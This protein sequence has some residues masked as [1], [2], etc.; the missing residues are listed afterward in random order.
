MRSTI[1][2]HRKYLIDA[3]DR[4]KRRAILLSVVFGLLCAI[5]MV[6][7]VG[8]PST[9][10]DGASSWDNGDGTVSITAERSSVEQVPSEKKVTDETSADIFNPFPNTIP[11]TFLVTKVV[12]GDTLYVQG[13]STRVRLIGVDTPETVSASKPIECYG[14][15]ASNFLKSLLLG[16]YVGLETDENVGD[17]D[18]YGRPLR[19]IYYGGVNVNYLI[20]AGGYGNE[21]S[22][23][24][25]YKYRSF[26]IEA[27]QW[28]R[29]NENGLWSPDT[30]NGLR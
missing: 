16:K 1:V 22:Y 26:F 23:G 9:D 7:V 10:K 13:L 5:L 15:E 6:G 21:A 29:D 18:I 27:E 17:T 11:E 2:R 30:C 4:K 25:N 24:N 14:P 20:I 3:G 12:D 8:E 28:A 19:Y